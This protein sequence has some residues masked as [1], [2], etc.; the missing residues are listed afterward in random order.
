MVR[1]LL[2]VYGTLKRGAANHQWLAGQTYLGDART[3]PGYRLFGL[4]GYPGMVP[5]PEDR[6]GVAGEVWSVEDACLEQLDAFEGVSERLYRR[7]RVPLLPPFADR[8]IEAYIYLH[9]VL[10]RP[11]IGSVWRGQS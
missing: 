6:E 8:Q 9:S 11:E 3:A 1:H 4:S 7:E 2:F 5:W 10:G